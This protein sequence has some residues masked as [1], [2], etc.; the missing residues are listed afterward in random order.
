[1]RHRDRD[2]VRVDHYLCLHRRRWFFAAV[3]DSVR[4]REAGAADLRTASE[5]A[6]GGRGRRL[7]SRQCDVREQRPPPASEQDRREL[8]YS[9]FYALRRLT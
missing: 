6:S 8:S 9:R 1:M 3:G 7:S 2:R 4:T 5:R